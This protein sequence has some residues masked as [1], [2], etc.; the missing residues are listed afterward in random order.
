MYLSTSDYLTKNNKNEWIV[1]TAG[2]GCCA[3]T[4]LVKFNEL[5]EKEILDYIQGVEEML[6]KGKQLLEEYRMKKT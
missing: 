3:D 5:E 2:C 4:E 6:A 1:H